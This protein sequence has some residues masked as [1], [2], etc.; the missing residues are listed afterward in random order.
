[1][2]KNQNCVEFEKIKHF[3]QVSRRKNK[4]MIKKLNQRKC[5]RVGKKNIIKKK[6]KL[7]QKHFL[8]KEKG[9]GSNNKQ[10]MSLEQ[11]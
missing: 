1:M 5:R 7:L 2:A 11:N 4:K 3:C 6:E 10:K 9:F 8:K